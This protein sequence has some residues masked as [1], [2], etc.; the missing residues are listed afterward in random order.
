MAR[1]VIGDIRC[2]QGLMSGPK[3][4]SDRATEAPINKKSINKVHHLTYQADVMIRISG[5][6]ILL[7]PQ[8]GVS[9]ANV[10]NIPSALEAG[11]SAI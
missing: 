1:Q 9:K 3:L 8:V 4:V 7:A 11:F 5:N 2:G 10:A 6:N